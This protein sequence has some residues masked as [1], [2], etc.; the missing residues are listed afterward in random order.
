MHP[1]ASFKDMPF[2]FIK[3][4]ATTVGEREIPAEQC[5]RIFPEPPFGILAASAASMT[6]QAE[7]TIFSIEDVAESVKERRW[8]AT[9]STM[10]A[11]VV[12]MLRTSVM[13]LD[14]RKGFDEAA[15]HGP[16]YRAGGRTR[17]TASDDAV[18][19]C[20]LPIVISI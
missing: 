8:Y 20:R 19:V 13:A 17:E 7:S 18:E 15:E 3:Y 10:A 6:S 9:D 4:A 2:L 1:S 16:R 5:T 14:V 12:P 11:G